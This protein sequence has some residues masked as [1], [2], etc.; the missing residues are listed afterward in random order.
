MPSYK[1]NQAADLLPKGVYPF[2]VRNAKESTSTTGNPKIELTLQV[3]GTFTVYDNL[4]FVE[5]SFWKIDQ[6]RLATGEVLGKPGSD[7]S[8]ESDDCIQ[9]RG[10]VSIDIDEFP[11]GS[12]RKRNIVTEYINPAIN[13]PMPAPGNVAA[14]NPHSQKPEPDNIPF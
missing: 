11:K 14:A 6:F 10:E 2:Y 12:G 8:L 3:N 5:N 1:Q 13:G 7:M 4:T 9:R